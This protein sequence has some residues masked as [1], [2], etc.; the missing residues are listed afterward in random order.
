MKPRNPV[1]LPRFLPLLALGLGLLVLAGCTTSSGDAGHRHT[2][3]SRALI[4]NTQGTFNTGAPGT[5]AA[6]PAAEVSGA[7]TIIPGGSASFTVSA[8]VE[9]T[10]IFLWFQGVDGF[11]E[12]TVPPTLSERLLI[13][14][15][16]N[17]PEEFYSL[18]FAVGT[19]NGPGA[20]ATQHTAVERVGTGSVQVSVSW[21]SPADVD[22]YLVE[23]DGFEI[24]YYTRESASGGTLDLD[25]NAACL[26]DDVRNENI[27]YENATPPTGEYTVRLNYWSDCGAAETN[28]VVTVRVEGQPVS[29]YQGTFTGLGV[30][31]GAGAGDVIDTFNFP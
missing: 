4:G 29:T 12:F 18:I 3:I 24:Y 2:L 23:P 22:L 25:S 20:T 8:A 31:G 26:S 10:Q 17:L 16:P 6:A 1:S 11:F 27:T 13:T 7:S 15:N 5:D 19:G 28:W 30:G 21:D 9:F 14:L